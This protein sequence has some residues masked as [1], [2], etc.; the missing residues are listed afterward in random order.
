MEIII[1]D[2][3]LMSKVSNDILPS[4][5]EELSM[6]ARIVEETKYKKK[7]ISQMIETYDKMSQK[8]QEILCCYS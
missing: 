8:R 4:I 1:D 5:K 2:I 6:I 3:S 7:I